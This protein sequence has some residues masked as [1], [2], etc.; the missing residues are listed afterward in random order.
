[1]SEIAD[2][3]LK[4]LS[5]WSQ[6]WLWIIRF[7]RNFNGQPQNP[8]GVGFACSY[9]DLKGRP[10][11]TVSGSWKGKRNVSIYLLFITVKS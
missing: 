9:P 8:L 7:L 5:R 2:Q 3:S 4:Y 1:M 11:G 6:V 10:Q